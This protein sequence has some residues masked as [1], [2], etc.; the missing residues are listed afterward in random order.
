MATLESQPFSSY[1]RENEPKSDRY[2]CS[3]ART[4]FLEAK[5]LFSAKVLFSNIV[6]RTLSYKTQKIRSKSVQAFLRYECYNTGWLTMNCSEARTLNNSVNNRPI[7][8]KF[9]Q[10][11][12]EHVMHLQFEWGRCTIKIMAAALIFVIFLLGE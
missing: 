2:H 4:L 12:D 3:E 1:K 9:G 6:G 8:L 5:Y 7:G 11:I 10:I